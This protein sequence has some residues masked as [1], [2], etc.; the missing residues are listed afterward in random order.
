MLNELILLDRM[1]E[2]SKNNDLTLMETFIF[3][4]TNSLLRTISETEE[5]KSYQK[6]YTEIENTMIKN[7]SMLS[8]SIFSKNEDFTHTREQVKQTLKKSKDLIKELNQSIKYCIANNKKRE[9]LALQRVRDDIIDINENFRKEYKDS[10]LKSLLKYLLRFFIALLKIWFTN[11]L[12]YI[13][14][15][16]IATG[17]VVGT[18]MAIKFAPLGIFG[19]F[20]V[21]YVSFI[22]DAWTSDSVWLGGL[23]GVKLFNFIATGL[24]SIGAALMAIGGVGLLSIL[25]SNIDRLI[26]ATM[27][28]LSS[29]YIK[30]AKLNNIKNQLEKTQHEFE[31]SI[32][33]VSNTLSQDAERY[34]E[35]V[36]VNQHNHNHQI[37]NF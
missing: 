30:N 29:L 5:Y 6:M 24:P 12:F 31:H 32:S 33:D 4:D 11:R 7:V 36:R 3:N 13:S 23:I 26:E 25:V 22:P 35:L 27:D 17:A 16:L 19:E 28:D 20:L 14:I 9:L 2:A 34:N 10:T 8:E 18:V 1:C 37:N 21:K 15:A